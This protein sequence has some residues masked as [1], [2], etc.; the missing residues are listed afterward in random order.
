MLPL[1]LILAA[2]WALALCA[3]LALCVGARR[4]DDLLALERERVRRREL[5]AGIVVLGSGPLAARDLRTPVA[6]GQDGAADLAAAASS[7]L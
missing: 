5:A 7:A 2:V 4:G 1:L 3:V 6:A